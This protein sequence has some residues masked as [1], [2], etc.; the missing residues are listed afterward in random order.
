MLNA[1]LTEVVVPDHVN[2][3]FG[4]LIFI[5]MRIVMERSATTLVGKLLASPLAQFLIVH[6]YSVLSDLAARRHCGDGEAPAPA[7]PSALRER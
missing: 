6:R 5:G 7:A 3:F 1:D 4:V 2:R